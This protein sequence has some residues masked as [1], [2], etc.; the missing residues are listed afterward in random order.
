[1]RRTSVIMGMSAITVLIGLAGVAVSGG[2]TPNEQLG[3]SIFFDDDLSINRNQ[4][5]ATCHASGV[6]W[7]GPDQIVNMHGSVYEGS[8]P[9]RFGDR[10]PARPP[11]MRRPAPSST[12]TREPGWA[13][14]SGMDGRLVTG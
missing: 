1:M 7:T 9:G 12:S 14:T 10:K 4:S 5:C 3:K 11:R 8:I 13:A 6:G 2:L